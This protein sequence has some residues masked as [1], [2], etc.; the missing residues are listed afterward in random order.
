MHATAS[1]WE[2]AA[3][4]A[5]HGFGDAHSALGPDVL[6]LVLGE[7]VGVVAMITPCNFP[8]LIVS[9]KLPFALAVGDPCFRKRAEHYSL[10]IEHRKDD[11]SVHDL[12]FLFWSSWKRWLDL[13]G[14]PSKDAVLVHA[15]RLDAEQPGLPPRARPP[16]G[17]DGASRRLPVRVHRAD[18]YRDELPHVRYRGH[19]RRPYA[20]RARLTL[21]LPRRREPL[22]SHSSSLPSSAGL[23][24]PLTI[25]AN[26][27]RVAATGQL[28]R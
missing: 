2:Y 22:G 9:Q 24:P 25:A 27:L 11:G 8:L 4:L 1:L 21:S 5:R 18:G 19:G 23:K 6:G 12:G 3:T 17:P 28:H 13:T 15:G 20:K 16:R 7:P 10:L 14:D 26:V